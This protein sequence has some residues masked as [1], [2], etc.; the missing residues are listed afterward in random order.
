MV[1]LH[2]RFAG[3]ALAVAPVPAGAHA[4]VVEIRD[5]A[6][7]DAAVLRV[8]EGDA[9]GAGVPSATVLNDAVVHHHVVADVGLSGPRRVAHDHTAA[10]EIVEVAVDHGRVSAAV[11]K[12]DRMPAHMGH[13]TGL[14]ANAFARGHLD[15]CSHA[16]GGLALEEAVGRIEVVVKLKPQTAEDEVACPF[17]RDQPIGNGHD[18]D[19]GVV[20][21][22][23]QRPVEKLSGRTVEKP[24][25]WAVEGRTIIF[26]P[27]SQGRVGAGHQRIPALPFDA[28]AA[29]GVVEVGDTG[30]GRAPVV[31]DRHEQ[32][33]PFGCRNRLEEGVRIGRQL[34]HFFLGGRAEIGEGI[35]GRGRVDVEIAAVGMTGPRGATAVDPELLKYPLAR[36]HLGNGG[37]PEAVPFLPAR[38]PFTTRKNWRGTW[39]RHPV[40][41]R[42]F[43]REHQW[44]LQ[45][46]GSV[47]HHDPGRLGGPAGGVAGGLWRA[48]RPGRGE[49][50]VSGGKRSSCEQKRGDEHQ[51]SHH[52]PAGGAKA[53]LL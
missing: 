10:A 14:D 46:I 36:L 1:V 52:G 15:R 22:P 43:R 25:P 53:G 34:K 5:V 3:D 29:G 51:R 35:G 49:E 6:V 28:N 23:R 24:F 32:I 11:V 8:G 47:G 42:V 27:E 30:L 7:G 48:D 45:E 13:G 38:D 41:L 18:C 2:E 40:G 9:A 16:R 39:G 44:L 17:D 26:Q 19:C 20:P 37:H 21:L 12:I 31:G 4:R 50:N 33:G